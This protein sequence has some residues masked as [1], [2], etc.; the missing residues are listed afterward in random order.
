MMTLRLSYLGPDVLDGI[1]GDDHKSLSGAARRL[2]PSAAASVRALAALGKKVRASDV[3]R[4]ASG[5]L[6]AVH[7]KPH[8]ALRPGYSPHNYGFS[9]DLAV[10]TLM[11]LWGLDKRGLDQLMDEHGWVCHRQ[12]HQRGPEDWHYNFLELPTTPDGIRFR[13]YITD[14]SRPAVEQRIEEAHGASFTMDTAA[15]QA[16]LAKLSMYAGPVDGVESKATHKAVLAF[17]HEWELPETGLADARTQR[18]LALV[19]A[20]IEMV[21]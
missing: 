8:L 6:A 1:Y 21:P 18:T 4:T 12:D 5:S 16:A 2:V 15:V 17:Q 11:K 14:S 13:K 19:A 10:D 7:N 3:L 9:V 20:D